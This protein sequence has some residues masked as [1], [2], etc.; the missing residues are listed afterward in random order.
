MHSAKI[1]NLEGKLINDFPTLHSRFP[2]S[3]QVIG[4]DSF[5]T[6]CADSCLFDMLV[7]LRFY[8]YLCESFCLARSL[9]ADLAFWSKFV[10]T[11]DPIEV[12]RT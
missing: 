3:G 11:V 1:A 7:K 5:T 6:A 9:A 4:A 2:T 10:L 8:G 12:T